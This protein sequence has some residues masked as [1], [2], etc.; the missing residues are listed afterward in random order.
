MSIMSGKEIRKRRIFKDDG[1]TVISALDMGMFNGTVPGLEDVRA[2]TQ[3]VV[4]A[5]VDAIIVG[6]GWAKATADIFGGKCGLILR[7]TGGVTPF[8]ADPLAHSLTTTVEEA[9][10]LLRQY[11]MH[12]SIGFAHHYAICDTTG[13]AV[14]VE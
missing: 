8:S 4:D 5:G 10:A 3:T 11:D 6:P 12:S 9:I 2:I 13:R 1:R 14:V 7:V